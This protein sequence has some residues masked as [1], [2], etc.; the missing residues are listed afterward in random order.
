MRSCRL[1]GFML[2]TLA[3]GAEGLAQEQPVTRP[4]GREVDPQ[5]LMDLIDQADRLVVLAQPAQDA[6]VLYETDEQA[7]LDA[8]KGALKLSRPEKPVHCMCLG[9]PII[10]LYSGETR[11]GEIRNHHAV[12]VRTSLWDSDAHITDREAYLSWFDERKIT[13]PRDEVNEE[14]KRQEQ[15]A[16]DRRRWVEAAPASVQPLLPE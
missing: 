5:A 11:I 13:P 10:L 7:D 6:Q 1:T 14:R 8:L 9:A 16:R 4:A 15:Y 3:L 2:I 12:L